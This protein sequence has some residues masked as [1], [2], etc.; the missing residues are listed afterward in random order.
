MANPIRRRGTSSPPPA[1]TRLTALTPRCVAR[2]VWTRSSVTGTSG[3]LV[4]RIPAGH[5]TLLPLN[6]DGGGSNDM[7]SLPGFLLRMPLRLFVGGLELFLR[8]VREFQTSYDE[9]TETLI[10]GSTE[11][12]RG[13]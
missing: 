5:W 6:Q 1:E 4:A 13:G 12:L 11:L 8:T 9:T 2:G 7:S 10:H 3:C